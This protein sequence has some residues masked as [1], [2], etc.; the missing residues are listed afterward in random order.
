MH[1]VILIDEDRRKAIALDRACTSLDIQVHHGRSAVEASAL[2]RKIE[3][4][5]VIVTGFLSNLKA[6]L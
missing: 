6:I 4:A 3:I 5:L 2:T 1:Q